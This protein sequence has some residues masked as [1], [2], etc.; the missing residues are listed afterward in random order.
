M[1][2]FQKGNKWRFKKGH[3]FGRRFKKGNI[4]WNKKKKPTKNVKLEGIVLIFIINLILLNFPNLGLMLKMVL[5][6]VEIVIFFSIDYME[7]RTI[8]LNN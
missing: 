5:L 3:K 2:I 7:K 6:C 8:L 4:P 1:P